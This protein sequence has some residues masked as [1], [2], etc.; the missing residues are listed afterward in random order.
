MDFPTLKGRNYEL[1]KTYFRELNPQLDL[2]LLQEVKFGIMSDLCANVF[3]NCNYGMVVTKEGDGKC[4]GI[5]YNPDKLSYCKT[6]RLSSVSQDLEQR[7]CVVTMELNVGCLTRKII[8]ASCHLPYKD[9]DKICNAKSVLK[10]LEILQQNSRCPFLIAGD[11]N[12]DLQLHIAT[13]QEFELP[14]YKVTEYRER[15]AGNRDCQIDYFAYKNCNSLVN[16]QLNNVVADTIRGT[17]EELSHHDPL[18]ATMTVSAQCY[19]NLLF[20]INVSN[21][22]SGLITTYLSSRLHR[23]DL[24]FLYDTTQQLLE[25]ELTT[26]PLQ[27]LIM[28]TVLGFNTKIFQIEPI[29]Y[30]SPNSIEVNNFYMNCQRFKNPIIVYL[31]HKPKDVTR[32]DIETLF[33]FLDGQ[34]HSVFVLG[35]FNIYKILKRHPDIDTRQFVI[36]TYKP[37]I[38][39]AIYGGVDDACID[40]FAYKNVISNGTMPIIT[41]L[42]VTAEMITTCPRDLV[43]KMDGQCYV[44]TENLALSE[45][46]NISSHDPL[47]AEILIEV[48]SPPLNLMCLNVRCRDDKEVTEAIKTYCGDLNPK[49]DLY[50]FHNLSEGVAE[51]IENTKELHFP[52]FITSRKLIFDNDDDGNLQFVEADTNGLKYTFKCTSFSKCPPPNIN[53][54][55]VYNWH[56]IEDCFDTASQ[57]D[58]PTVIAG[59]FGIDL[60]RTDLHKYGFEV[61]E[62]NPSTGKHFFTYKNSIAHSSTIALHNARAEKQEYFTVVKAEMFIKVKL[63]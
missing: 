58:Y 16:I 33:K 36:R 49:P 12:C 23:L 8:V 7:V 38:H 43:T 15:R 11:F 27:W 61:P 1:Q 24:C 42:N 37:T 63:H 34:S 10:A 3:S 51:E 45:V 4:N 40:F 25:K 14:T 31:C 46:H 53:V 35:D 41:H 56:T 54:A 59:F 55:S 20:F 17:D 6:N 5:L 30:T 48:E 29:H 2:I 28:K 18:R 57:Y 47:R 13:L 32:E 26:C 60:L 39:R 21:K 50:M 44:D 52:T 9:T 62:H 19:A 22:S